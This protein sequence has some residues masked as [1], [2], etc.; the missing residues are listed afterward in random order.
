ML[1]G[2]E[3]PALTVLDV[4]CTRRLP[5]VRGNRAF[6]KIWLFS[7]YA[8]R[9]ERALPLLRRSTRDGVSVFLLMV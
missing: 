3:K 1:T 9:G 2:A 7:E 8:G 6:V 5:E 4:I